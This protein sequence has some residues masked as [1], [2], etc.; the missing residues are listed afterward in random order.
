MFPDNDKDRNWLKRL[1]F[2]IAFSKKELSSWHKIDIYLNT[3]QIM[4]TMF[5]NPGWHLNTWVSIQVYNWYMAFK[6]KPR[7]VS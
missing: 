4:I 1:T 3:S 2:Q 6:P 7:K 5:T